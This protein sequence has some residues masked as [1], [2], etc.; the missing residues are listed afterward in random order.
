MRAPVV[1]KGRQGRSVNALE[2][3][4]PHEGGGDPFAGLDGGAGVGKR[5][6]PHAQEACKGDMRV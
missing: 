6:N 5:G 4:D 3:R 2:V 1:H